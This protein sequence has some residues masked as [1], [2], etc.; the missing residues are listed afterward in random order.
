MFSEF[1]Y[2]EM[3]KIG[4]LVPDKWSREVGCVQI[5]LNEEKDIHGSFAIDGTVIV[6][7]HSGSDFTP[8]IKEV[9]KEVGTSFTDPTSEEALLYMAQQ[10]HDLVSADEDAAGF[11]GKE[12]DTK[13]REI[14]EYINLATETDMEKVM[15][16]PFWK[17]MRSK[18]NPDRKITI[19]TY[20]TRY[21]KQEQFAVRF[22][23]PFSCNAKLI[24][25]SKPG[26]V[27]RLR[28]TDA[29]IQKR[30]RTATMFEPLIEKFVE[31]V[32]RDNLKR[33]GVFCTAG[34]HRSVALGEFIGAYVY[35]NATVKHLTIDR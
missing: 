33:A 22:N 35:P 25:S 5:V 12:S 3:K 16:D 10:L 29:A 15:K 20:G 19:F 24:N 34:H 4:P 17:G 11:Y 18:A 30:V 32:E 27:H 23:A 7:N 8:L 21:I 9:E 2:N 26:N 13:E 14:A 1:I 6:Y 31:I 28:G